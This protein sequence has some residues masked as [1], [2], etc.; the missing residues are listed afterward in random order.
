MHHDSASASH[1]C[2]ACAP[3]PG[4]RCAGRPRAAL[5]AAPPR[6]Q[7]P[8]R[9]HARL[10][11]RRPRLPRRGA[12]PGCSPRASLRRRTPRTWR[13]NARAAAR[14]RPARAQASPDVPSPSVWCV[15][16]PRHRSAP[17][18]AACLQA[19]CAGLC[20]RQRPAGHSG[21]RGSA[22]LAA[23]SRALAPVARA[24]GGRAYEWLDDG[25]ASSAAGRRCCNRLLAAAAATARSGGRAW[26]CRWA[27]WVGGVGGGGG[28]R[29]GPD[30][31]VG[32]GSQE[33]PF[34]RMDAIARN[35]AASQPATT[36]LAEVLAAPARTGGR[37]RR[38][39]G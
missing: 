19:A 22:P 23:A 20:A 32:A 27:G 10:R 35:W 1:G 6:T 38:G 30:D 33:G 4:C 2:L 3:S 31:G 28:D 7:D 24:R 11:P 26:A 36:C 17:P 37:R 5:P 21:G 13:R 34:L 12:R 15:C 14:R 16:L 39:E 9:A 18:R 25:G 8:R 29:R